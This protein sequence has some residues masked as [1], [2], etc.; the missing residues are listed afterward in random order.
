MR[1]RRENDDEE[2]LLP[3]HATANFD[4]EN[5]PLNS[6]KYQK[7]PLKAIKSIIIAILLVILGISCFVFLI[8]S[9]TDMLYY[10]FHDH[11]LMLLLIGSVTIPCG[12]YTLYIAY[13]C[14]YMIGHCRW[15]M[16]FF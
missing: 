12:S 7:I 9:Y 8:L 2:R 10:T 16:I 11:R 5:G 3:E 6:S 1:L 15:P 4:R 13:H 14:Y